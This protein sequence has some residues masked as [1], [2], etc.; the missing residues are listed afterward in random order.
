MTR[1]QE[2]RS[3]VQNHA[4]YLYSKFKHVILSWATGVGKSLA[5]IKIIAEDVRIGTE[6]GNWNLWY[7]VCAERQHI[8]NWE[9]EFR[10]HG[11]GELL[12]LGYVR[13]F[14]YQSLHRYSTKANLVLD[15]AHSVTDLRLEILKQIK[16]D[17]VVSLSASLEPDR[18][19]QLVDLEPHLYQYIITTDDAIKAG[20]LDSP[21]VVRVGHKLFP[22]LRGAYDE[23]TSTI[24]RLTAEIDQ[25]NI[26]LVL[27][28]G[29]NTVIIQ[30]IED[31]IK[32]INNKIL[33]TKVQRKALLANSK[34]IV[35]LALRNR[36]TEWGKKQIIFT[37]TT[38]QCGRLGN[39]YSVNSLNTTKVNEKLIG[40]FNNGTSKL[41][42][43]NKMLR[44]GTNLEGIEVGIICQ[45]DAKQLSFT[46][47]MGR[48]FR[49]KRP[50]LFVF[51]T[52][53][54][55]DEIYWNSCIKGLDPSYIISLEDYLN[56][57]H[58]KEEN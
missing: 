19:S 24:T 1:K 43:C 35:A 36:I 58:G 55:V 9:D 10:K 57:Y 21:L 5:A 15:E 16:G 48:I 12:D 26:K 31:N 23:Y 37:G 47:M 25:L 17:S 50:I 56:H 3:K 52:E 7:I 41:L 53:D 6:K 14:C 11:Y 18:R 34:T 22:R 30:E 40:E 49:S 33:K 13:I 20:I 28:T 27:A 45:L 4:L 51:V 46:Q 54:T 2:N 8:K 32:D 38:A 44:Q 29:A 39:G 42:V